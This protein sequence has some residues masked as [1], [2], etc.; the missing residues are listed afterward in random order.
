[1]VF[2][3][4]LGECDGK[5]SLQTAVQSRGGPIH[6]LL[7]Q[8]FGV[9]MVII[10]PQA[11]P[12]DWTAT[13]QDKFL[14]HVL[15]LFGTKIDLD[16]FY[17]A[18]LSLGGRGAARYLTANNEKVAAAVVICPAQG[19]STTTA[20]EMLTNR[21]PLWTAVAQGDGTVDPNQALNMVS[22]VWKLLGWN[23][24][25]T[26]MKNDYP[27][28][29]A[30]AYFDSNAKVHRWMAGQDY[31]AG[32]QD[33]TPP[34]LVTLYPDSSHNSWDRMFNDPKIYEWLLKFSKDSR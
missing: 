33:I 12:C 29:T 2:F 9:P 20:Q 30:T 10:H 26:V 21:V 15:P 28:S 7:T 3:H 16:R 13:Q 1:M 31:R 14:N 8:K 18:G 22:Y 11:S 34:Y 23:S 24:T 32:G 5:V 4:G 6:S 17:V 19:Y 27:D 25:T